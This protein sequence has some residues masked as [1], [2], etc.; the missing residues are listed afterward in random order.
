MTTIPASAHIDYAVSDRSGIVE[1]THQIHAAVVDSTGKLLYTLGNPLRMTLARSAAK[2]LQALGVLESGAFEKFGLDQ[3]DLALMCGSHNGED[4]HV[5]R[6]RSIL[7]KSGSQERFYRCGGHPSP[8]AVLN[9]AWI[10]D[11][12]EPLPVN[13]NCSGKHAG[14]MAGAKALGADV[15]TYHSPDNPIQAKIRQVTQKLVGIPAE[16]IKWGL[17]GCNTYA[18]AFPLDRLAFINAALAQAAGDA[19]RDPKALSAWEISLSKLFNAMAS[20][21]DLIGGTDRF[22]TVLIEAYKGALIGKLG[23]DACYGIGILESEET[24]RLGAKGGLGIA[25]KVEDGSNDVVYAATMEI[26]EQLQ[27]G[28]PEMRKTL[29]RFHHVKYINSA[30]VETGQLSLPF[31]VRKV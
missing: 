22:C 17:D 23:A 24:R 25:V 6:A 26:L 7:A 11:G 1:N 13:S 16:D 12:Y 20:Y 21:P 28:T 4:N 27:L 9:K 2:P 30:G 31:K 8:Y 19:E 5:E 15:E 14:M 10:R 18:P 3:G 29:D